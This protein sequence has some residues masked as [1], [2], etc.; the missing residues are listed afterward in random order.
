MKRIVISLVISFFC[1]P[2][3]SV[4]QVN[5]A[6]FDK[7]ISIRSGHI[8]LDSLL[9]QFARQTGLEFSFPANK[10]SPAR[11][12]RVKAQRQS[13]TVWLQQ[14]EQSLRIRHKVVG[15]HIIL[16]EAV[17]AGKA[18]PSGKAISDKRSG[19]GSGSSPRPRI[20][21]DSSK[22]SDA[23]PGRA[24][25]ETGGQ[26]T[27]ERDAP[28]VPAR[29]AS[30]TPVGATSVPDASTDVKVPTASSNAAEPALPVQGAVGNPAKVPASPGAVP[31]SRAVKDTA[32]KQARPGLPAAP[33]GQAV[34]GSPGTPASAA[35]PAAAKPAR[36]A[37]KPSTRRSSKPAT[38]GTSNADS[39][40]GYDREDAA[41]MEFFQ[42][43]LGLNHNGSGDMDGIAFATTY[44]HYLS[45][46]FSLN[47]D[48]RGLMNWS[49]HTLIEKHPITGEFVDASVRFTTASAQLG[50]LAGWSLVQTGRHEL[51]GLAGPFGR[52]Q[53]SSN[54]DDGY[55][56]YYPPVTGQPTSLIGY[57]NR[58][59]QNKF[60]V[61]YLLSLQYQFTFSNNLCLGLAAVFQNDTNGDLI[62]QAGI[63]VGKRF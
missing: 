7:T 40:A 42:L 33:P 11:E 25:G 32:K 31:A 55:S 38:F 15:N 59:P 51:K 8:R 2:A 14:L 62:P 54:G 52:F 39:E 19:D 58:T 1:M 43:F 10:V 23:R 61:G 22:T 48:L 46:R 41:G 28:A 9:H 3:V 20:V 34:S 47:L 44:S 24:A 16:Y 21:I 6:V 45:H 36:A 37:T 27:D 63:T 17:N 50:V 4:A 29:P 12:L 56:V 49:K 60:T 13:L 53:S 30:G 5:K 57:D 26:T 35:T 18:T